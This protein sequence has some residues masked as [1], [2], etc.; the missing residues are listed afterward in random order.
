[1]NPTLWSIYPPLS[2]GL[3]SYVALRE[4]FSLLKLPQIVGRNNGIIVLE[5]RVGV[6]VFC[7]DDFGLRPDYSRIRG[8]LLALFAQRSESSHTYD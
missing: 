1:M 2:G 7:V 8:A 6:V 4:C 3:S 5:I